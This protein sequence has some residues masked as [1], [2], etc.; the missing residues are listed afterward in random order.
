MES[1]HLICDVRGMAKV[2]GF[3]LVLMAAACA[4][5][6]VTPE[7]VDARAVLPAGL[8]QSHYDRHYLL[9]T[10]TSDEDLPFT[11]SPSFVL[12]EPRLVW[13]GAY[14]RTPSVWT[15][16]TPEVQVV[17]RR[18][19]FPEFVHGGCEVVNVVSDAFT[20]ETLASWCNVDHSPSVDVMPQKSRFYL[21]AH[22]PFQ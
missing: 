12:S 9:T 22:S 20:G 19:Q 5:G 18:D 2:S 10:I 1:G 16:A 7:T 15:D 17:E 21:P 11:T 14:A 3:A 13:V 8:D 6:T 4:P